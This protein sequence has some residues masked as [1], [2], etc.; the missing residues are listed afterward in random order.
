MD[1]LAVV[2]RASFCGCVD[3]ADVA[4]R[5]EY[6]F[7]YEELKIDRK[8]GACIVTVSCAIIG[9]F[10]SLSLGATDKLSFG[11]KTLF[12]WFDFVTV[13]LFLPYGRS[14]T[15]LVP[16]LVCSEEGGEG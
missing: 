3:I 4:P 8:K 11:G 13:Q 9:A 2:L 12:D 1:Y 15:C 5:G 16:G 10:C 6:S 7:F 14:S